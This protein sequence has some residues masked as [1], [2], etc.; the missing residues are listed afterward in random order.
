MSNPAHS[1]GESCSSAIGIFYSPS[2]LG[3]RLFDANSQ[4]FMN[5]YWQNTRLWKCNTLH[6][7]NTLLHIGFPCFLKWKFISRLR[8]DG[9]TFIK[10]FRGSSSNGKHTIIIVLYANRDYFEEN[11]YFIHCSILSWFAQSAG[12][13]E[14]T[15][16]LSAEG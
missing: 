6:I 4:F 15:D 9:V 7:Y 16:C 3:C 10:S 13:V 2:Q 11:L 8:S 1:S 14:Y 12:A 5:S